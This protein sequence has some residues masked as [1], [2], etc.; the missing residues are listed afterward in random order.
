VTAR[1]T[2]GDGRCKVSEPTLVD[3]LSGKGYGGTQFPPNWAL[4]NESAVE[5]NRLEAAL[6]DAC[7]LLDYDM[8]ARILRFLKENHDQR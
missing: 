5:I 7:K 4:C 1:N 8:R 3:R 6:R 2:D